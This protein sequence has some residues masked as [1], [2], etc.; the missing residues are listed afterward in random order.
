MK[1]KWIK[2]IEPKTYLEGNMVINKTEEIVNEMIED[3]IDAFEEGVCECID[4]KEF[5]DY[6]MIIFEED[7]SREIVDKNK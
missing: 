3:E 2:F 5:G 6:I 7:Y 4:V 1:R